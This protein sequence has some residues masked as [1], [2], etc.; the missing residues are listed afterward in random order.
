MMINQSITT[1]AIGPI[2]DSPRQMQRN[3]HTAFCVDADIFDLKCT[4][5]NISN[6]SQYF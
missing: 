2:P 1:K 5:N 6:I 3:K 4:P